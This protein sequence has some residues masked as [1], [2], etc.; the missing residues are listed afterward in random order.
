MEK[1]EHSKEP[2]VKVHLPVR[3]DY[4]VLETFLRER[5]KGEKI[6]TEKE[7][8]EVTNYAEILNFSLEKSRHEDFDLSVYISFK[9]LTTF[10]KNKEGEVLV[11]LSLY[12]DEDSQ[13]V[14]VTDYRL[15]GN[16]EGWLINKV[17]PSVVNTFLHKKLKS[18][19]KLA[20]KSKIEEQVKSLN[21]KLEE[22]LKAAEGIYLSGELNKLKVTDIVVGNSHF[23]VSVELEGNAMAEIRNL[24]FRKKD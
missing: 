19:M 9:T 16:S 8:G 5:M 12:F 7:N 14:L 1:T 21:N 17:L 2:A 13:E 6:K 11:D 22:E 23:L 15:K 18:K 3:I 10:F 20:F 4:H 24:N